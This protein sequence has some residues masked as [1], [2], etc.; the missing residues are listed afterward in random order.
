MNEKDLAIIIE[1][2][3]TKC[4]HWMAFASWYSI[5]K[6]ISDSQVY[7][8]LKNYNSKGLFGW[9]S[10]CGVRIFRNQF[11]IDRPIVKV[12]QPSIMA[13]RELI[14]LEIASSKSDVMATFVDYKFGCG[15]FVLD[16]WIN[17]SEV[18]FENALK[19]FSTYDLNVNELAILNLWEQCDIS[20]K[21]LG[22][23]N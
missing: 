7:L 18:P 5:Q 22:G 4:H 8:I 12:I 10:R 6:K 3:V 14:N 19:K 2:D 20:Y 1:C 23:L 11:K 16:N 21:A 17:K 9:T 15:S 13:I